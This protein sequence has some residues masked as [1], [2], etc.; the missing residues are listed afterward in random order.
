MLVSHPKVDVLYN[1]NLDDS[2]CV[3]MSSKSGCFVQSNFGSIAAVAEGGLDIY[4]FSNYRELSLLQEHI[5]VL[6]AFLTKCRVEDD[7]ELPQDVWDLIK[8]HLHLVQAPFQGCPPTPNLYPPTDDPLSFFPCLPKCHGDARYEADEKLHIPQT[9]GCRK[10]SY[11]HPTLSQI[12]VSM[13]CAMG[14]KVLQTCE[15][16]KHP[17]RIFKTRFF[18]ACRLHV[19]CL[20]REPHLYHRE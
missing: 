13:E 2:E 9:D 20:N 7:G 16:P 14:L 6:A 8:L 5:P 12:T 3:S 1:P 11:G 17:F 15:S 10:A 18:F 19:Y 4:D